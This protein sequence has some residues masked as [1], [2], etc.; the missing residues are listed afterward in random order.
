MASS[1]TLQFEYFRLDSLGRLLDLWN[2]SL[3]DIIIDIVKHEAS[4]TQKH[5]SI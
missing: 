3:M 1:L 2:S 5:M 4:K